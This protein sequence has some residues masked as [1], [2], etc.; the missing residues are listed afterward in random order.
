MAPRVLDVSI[1][2]LD[3]QIAKKSMSRSEERA[4]IMRAEREAEEVET[5]A[6]AQGYDEVA[7]T[8]VD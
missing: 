4:I 3:A 8:R 1:V 6:S 7:T 2:L 5:A